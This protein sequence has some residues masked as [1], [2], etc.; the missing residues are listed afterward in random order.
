[1]VEKVFIT[2][3]N[4]ATFVCPQCGNV[5]TA[6]VAKY[7]AIDKKITVKCR[8][9]C[10]HRFDVSLEK[11]RQYRKA[12]DLPGTFYY[13]Q[14]TGDMDKGIMRVV[15]VSTTGLKLKLNVQPRFS[16]GEMLDVEFHLDDK[17]H[18]LLKK[19]VVV[20]NIYKNLVG[21]AF[22]PNEGDDPNL[23]FYLMS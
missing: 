8:C 20:R 10:G 23:G 18:T 22:A 3:N 9:N 16:I 19:R 15:D 1:M 12:T 4:K 17:R 2:S 7:A 21:T 13:R 5:T 14:D 11:R 6:N